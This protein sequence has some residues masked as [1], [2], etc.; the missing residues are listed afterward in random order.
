MRYEGTRDGIEYHALAAT[1]GG[2]GHDLPKAGFLHHMDVVTVRKNRFTVAA[3]PIG[4]VIDPKT[5][6]ATRYDAITRLLQG[7]GEQIMAFLPKTLQAQTVAQFSIELSNPTD[8]PVEFTTEFTGLPKGLTITPDHE[9]VA[10]APAGR[11]RLRFKCLS[12]K[13][14]TK[15]KTIRLRVHTDY[16]ARDTRVSLPIRTY[17]VIKAEAKKK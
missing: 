4:A 1:G 13:T 6:D 5:F 15:S 2:L 9:H 11:K 7:K 17:K 16:L 3:L 10:L 12:G 14:T 8:R